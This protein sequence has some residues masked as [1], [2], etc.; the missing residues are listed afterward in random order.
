M[1]PFRNGGAAL[2]EQAVAPLVDF[3]V[4]GGLDGV[5][6]LGTTG[7][8]ILLSTPERRRA[9]ELFVDAS[10]GRLAVAVH[11]GAQTTDETVQLAAHAAETS[12]DA[13]AVIAPP[14]YA[15]DQRSLV[16][17]FAAA[18]SVCAPLPFYLYEF[19]ARSG[20]AVPPAVIEGLRERAPTL[21]GLKVSGAVSGLASAFP[22]LV[23]GL[24]REPSYE[25]AAHVDALRQSLERFPFQS[26]VK[27]VLGRRGVPVSDDVRA[28]LR[29]LTGEE[30]AELEQVMDEWP[31]TSS[32]AQ[33]P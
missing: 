14:Y 29:R 32:Q 23:A 30:A 10:G 8:G 17:H 15:L 21:A 20:Y 11:C 19:A 13:V 16:E 22:E 4:H 27:R 3:L 24:V 31:A 33:A 28:P 2:D 9:A 26:A 6:A 5:L 25:G 7:E 18:A 1:T 12:A